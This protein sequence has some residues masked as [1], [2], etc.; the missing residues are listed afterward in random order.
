MVTGEGYG[1]LGHAE[2]P[3]GLGWGWSAGAKAFE[4]SFSNLVNYDSFVSLSRAH[5]PL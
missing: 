5:L 3:L 1:N 4:L 2:R